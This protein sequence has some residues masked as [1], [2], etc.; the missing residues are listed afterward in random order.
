MLSSPGIPGYARHAEAINLAYAQRHGY[1]F[2]VE[3]CPERVDC[4]WAW[5][6]EDQYRFVWHKAEFL[7]KH[8][9]RY[10]VFVYVDSDAYFADFDRSILD[11]VA[12]QVR[13]S[14][15]VLMVA[16]DC[17]SEGKCWNRG[18]PNAGVVVAINRPGGI[19]HETLR[20][21]VRAPFDG[22]E[23]VAWRD[24]HPREQAC[25]SDLV[26]KNPDFAARVQVLVPGSKMG[27]RDGTFLR[28]LLAMKTEEREKCLSSEH[29][30]ILGI[31]SS[32]SRKVNHESM[33][34]MFSVVSTFLLALIVTICVF[35]FK[36]KQQRPESRR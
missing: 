19:S 15:T 21:W 5:K 24:K 13:D 2:V 32:S 26:D 27:Q 31:S 23:C 35:A 33:N 34:I 12:E 17:E 28:H 10:H 8:L 3:R 30:K 20:R 4:E 1:D 18:K 25:L 7:A 36:T 6:D 16:E 14:N 9:P 11:F 22:G 29:L